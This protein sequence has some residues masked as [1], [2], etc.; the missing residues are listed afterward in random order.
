MKRRTATRCEWTLEGAMIELV[1]F[2]AVGALLALPLWDI[3]E[4]QLGS[5]YLFSAVPQALGAFFGLMLAVFAFGAQSV[6][7]VY[8]VS[9]WRL[10]S[11]DKR[12]L[13]LE[14][15]FVL[16]MVAS[17]V[18]VPY[19]ATCTLS[20]P[21]DDL[22]MVAAVAWLLRQTVLYVGRV[23]RLLRPSGII[24]ELLE[25]VT[26]DAVVSTLSGLKPEAEDVISSVCQVL[27]CI[28]DR[29]ELDEVKKAWQSIRSCLSD[30]VAPGKDAAGRK[31]MRDFVSALSGAFEGLPTPKGSLMRNIHDYATG[32][33][34]DDL[35]SASGLSH[36]RYLVGTLYRWGLRE[37]GRLDK[38]APGQVRAGLAPV[39]ARLGIKCPEIDRGWWANLTRG[40]ARAF[41]NSI[42]PEGI[43][44]RAVDVKAFVDESTRLADA[45]K[46]PPQGNEEIPLATCLG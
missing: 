44:I 46:Y 25:R 10:L 1:I 12:T 39:T 40:E 33:L 13:L 41:L 24:E 3:E 15:S 27:G 8:G 29:N 23:F 35:W 42:G 37:I 11:G 43:A 4:A 36:D 30:M 2:L 22:M 16:L 18:L 38:L 6:A 14:V 26:V 19:S 9:P 20:T 31:R 34:L 17:F 7:T 5:A 32:D 21:L 45:G 28:I